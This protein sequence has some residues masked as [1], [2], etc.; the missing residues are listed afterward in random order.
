MSKG[1]CLSRASNRAVSA[2]AGAT[3]EF[4]P[5]KKPSPSL[6]RGCGP[7]HQLSSTYIAPLTSCP[8]HYKPPSKPA[9]CDPDYSRDVRAGKR[10]IIESHLESCVDSKLC[11][12]YSLGALVL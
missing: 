2:P 11:G 4:T 3:P 1:E 9:S 8:R 10:L 12:F 7:R 6:N 5:K